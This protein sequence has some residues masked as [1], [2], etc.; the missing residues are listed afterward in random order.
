MEFQG[1]HTAVG[2]IGGHSAFNATDLQDIQRFLFNVT[3]GES[4]ER[5]WS[6]WNAG[7]EADFCIYIPYSL[8]LENITAMSLK[9]VFFSPLHT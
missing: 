9:V 6:H 7:R 5:K 3:Q 2:V 8:S 4:G 1:R